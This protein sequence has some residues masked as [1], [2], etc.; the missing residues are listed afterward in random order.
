LWKELEFILN[1]GFVVPLNLITPCMVVYD[2][3]A[4]NAGRYPCWV[5][6]LATTDEDLSDFSKDIRVHYFYPPALSA[7]KFFTPT[8]AKSLIPLPLFSC[9]SKKKKL[10]S[11]YKLVVY[12]LK[13]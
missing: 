6:E 4:A 11:P 13:K 8:N 5:K 9:N 2:I 7:R 10:K 12:H 3:E 1:K